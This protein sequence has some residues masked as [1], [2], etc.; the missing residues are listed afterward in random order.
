MKEKAL[1]LGKEILRFVFVDHLFL[2]LIV[3]GLIFNDI[4]MIAASVFCALYFKLHDILE[5]VEGKDIDIPILDLR[6]ERKEETK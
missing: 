4:S 5:A 1:L 2:T 3:F 6:I